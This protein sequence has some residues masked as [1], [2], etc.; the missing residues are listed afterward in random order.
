LLAYA[1]RRTL[2]TI[3]LLLFVILFTYGLMRG[4][5]GSPFRLEFGG[6]PRSLELQLREYYNLDE[7]WFVELWTYLRHIATLDFG[8]SLVERT[9]TVDAV[10][11]QRF[12]VT[13]HLALLAALWAVAIGTGLGLFAAVRRGTALDSL[14]TTAATVLTVVPVFLFA[15]LF[16]TYLVEDWR[17]VPFGWESARSKATAS[18]VLALAPAGYVARLVRAGAVETLEQDYVR[19]ARAKGLDR[20]RVLVV[21]V[22]RNSLTPVLAAAV[23]VLVLLVTGTF[24]V[25]AAF[26]V[27]GVSDQF[28][29]SA[30]RR[31]YP[32]VMGLTTALAAVVLTVNLLADLAAAALDPRILE[33]RR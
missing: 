3:P 1:L 12:P 32:M 26:G 6:L 8:P 18:F 11:E 31:D 33:R 20:R 25:E 29:E 13:G 17:L 14:V 23:P 27:P 21:H 22:L 5:G 9:V 16:A 7:P 24:F 10:I 4:I 19:T 2:A 30:R 28:L 15:D